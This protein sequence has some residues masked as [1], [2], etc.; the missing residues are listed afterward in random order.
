MSR[1]LFLEAI[2]G[3]IGL[4]IVGLIIA[5]IIKLVGKRATL[6][7]WPIWLFAILGFVRAI[8]VGLIQ[9]SN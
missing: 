3:A 9:N 8:G 6:P 1:D 2:G 4:G 5:F 7:K